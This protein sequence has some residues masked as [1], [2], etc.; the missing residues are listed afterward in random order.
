V[1]GNFCPANGGQT[2]A[3]LGCR[4]CTITR[5]F[6]PGVPF[7]HAEHP[8]HGETCSL[9]GASIYKKTLLLAISLIIN[10]FKFGIF[11]TSLQFTDNQLFR[12]M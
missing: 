3:R 6:V 4:D 7:L 9:S 2:Q 11:P 8:E 1:N 10:L 12:I 5:P